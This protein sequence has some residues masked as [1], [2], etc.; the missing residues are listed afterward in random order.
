MKYFEMKPLCRYDDISITYSNSFNYQPLKL[1]DYLLKDLEKR[2]GGEF[3]LTI[4]DI[5]KFG[6]F[7]I[8]AQDKALL[9]K[10]IKERFDDIMNGFNDDIILSLTNAI[11]FMYNGQV[12]HIMT[13]E[14]KLLIFEKLLDCGNKTIIENYIVLLYNQFNECRELLFEMYRFIPKIL[15]LDIDDEIWYNISYKIL[16]HR[17]PYC[18]DKF[19][20]E[21]EWGF[22]YNI[23]YMNGI[24]TFKITNHDAYECFDY[25]STIKSMYELNIK[26]D[27][28]KKF[29]KKLMRIYV[30]TK[31]KMIYD[32]YGYINLN[33]NF[34][35]FMKKLILYTDIYYLMEYKMLTKN[36]TKEILFLRWFVKNIVDGNEKQYRH[37]LTSEINY[38]YFESVKYYLDNNW[39][40]DNFV[41]EQIDYLLLDEICEDNY[42]IKY[43]AIN[44]E[45]TDKQINMLKRLKIKNRYKGDR[46]LFSLIYNKYREPKVNDFSISEI[47]SN[48]NMN[49]IKFFEEYC[50]EF[51]YFIKK[52][53]LSDL[54]A[55][56][57]YEISKDKADTLFY[58]L[59]KKDTRWL[60]DNPN[61]GDLKFLISFS[62]DKRIEKYIELFIKKIE[63]DRDENGNY[64]KAVEDKRLEAGGMDLK[65]ILM[66]N[67]NRTI[68]QTKEVRDIMKKNIKLLFSDKI[69]KNFDFNN[70]IYDCNDFFFEE[71]FRY[72]NI[73]NLSRER[74][75]IFVYCF[76]IKEEDLDNIKFDECLNLKDGNAY[77]YPYSKNID[78]F[79]YCL[80]NKGIIN[81][82][83]KDNK[84]L[85]LATKYNL[86]KTLHN[87]LKHDNIDKKVFREKCFEEVSINDS[88]DLPINKIIKRYLNE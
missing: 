44:M 13:N 54:Y 60:F 37:N 84:Y 45:G 73:C 68:Y 76:D 38:K 53:K 23:Y 52:I 32:D 8:T 62:F 72:T 70:C 16:N 1:T 69:L 78:Y 85:I 20:Y 25:D 77:Y 87:M 56:N 11:S 36:N 10:K 82:N 88:N 17:E 40:K 75:D 51:E 80:Y 26:G 59:N 3:G 21:K 83:M 27:E 49:K 50:S 81:G 30:L 86:I 24:D 28:I 31:N 42:A 9:N 61:I 57:F 41:P 12:N 43:Y 39:I 66:F 19:C 55:T 33:E 35:T 74:S 14:D 6:E 47:I 79:F 34:Y 64:I 29:I 63:Y 5:K 7:E 15:S 58:L 18:Y 22:I 71:F 48:I 4:E 65:N 67:L 2:Y 46:T